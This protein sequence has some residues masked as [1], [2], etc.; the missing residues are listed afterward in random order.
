MQTSAATTANT[1]EYS[2][3]RLNKA[4]LKDVARLHSAV[5]TPVVDDHYFKKYDTIYTGIENIGFIA[6]KADIPIAYYGVI[7]C[8][9]EFGDQK[10]LAAQ[11]V[12]T[13][14][15]PKFRMK[16]MFME[17]SNKTFELCRE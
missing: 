15:H 9:I 7:P 16:G 14:T 2:I 1:K 11:S 13:M 17:L 12:D 3:V 10:I 5:Y 8:F 6:Y 4:N